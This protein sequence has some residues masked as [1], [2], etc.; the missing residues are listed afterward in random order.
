[1]KTSKMNED[2]LY[3]IPDNVEI[4]LIDSSCCSVSVMS[5]ECV[6]KNVSCVCHHVFVPTVPFPESIADIRTE[7]TFELDSYF[8]ALY[9]LELY[10]FYFGS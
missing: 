6:S 5:F 2:H 4:I 3:I 1:M 7:S 10:G 9:I 8:V